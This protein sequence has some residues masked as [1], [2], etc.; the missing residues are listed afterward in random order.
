MV[1]YSPR[2]NIYNYYDRLTSTPIPFGQ[3]KAVRVTSSE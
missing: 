1:L 2:E 3:I